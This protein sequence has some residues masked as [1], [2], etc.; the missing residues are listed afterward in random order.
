M[1]FKKIILTVLISSLC[2]QPAEGFALHPGVAKA[3]GWGLGIGGFVGFGKLLQKIEG[4]N[5][6]EKAHNAFRITSIIASKLASHI[7][8]PLGP[9]QFNW[10]KSVASSLWSEAKSKP[11][12][13]VAGITLAAYPFMNMIIH[14]TV[15][16]KEFAQYI[17]RTTGQVINDKVKGEAARFM[18]TWGLLV[19]GGLSALAMYG[20][21][22][23]NHFNGETPNNVAE[24]ES[25][26]D[27]KLTCDDAPPQLIKFIDDANANRKKIEKN[28]TPDDDCD[29]ALLLSGP[30]GTGK[31][32]LSK[33]I[34]QQITNNNKNITFIEG[35]KLTSRYLNN[36]AVNVLE[37]YEQAKTLARNN[38]NNM[39]VIV[40]DDFH[41]LAQSRVGEG[42]GER[43]DAKT[44][45]S[46]RTSIDNLNDRLK[47]LVMIA[48]T[49]FPESIDQTILD[50]FKER[51]HVDLPN[52]AERY[53]IIKKYIE[54]DSNISAT[55]ET[56][57]HIA[58]YTKELNKRN[59]KDLCRKIRISL[60]KYIKEQYKVESG[61]IG[62]DYNI[63]RLEINEAISS[64][65][66][67]RTNFYAMAIEKAKKKRD[68]LEIQDCSNRAEIL[69]QSQKDLTTDTFEYAG[70]LNE[71]KI[72]DAYAKKAAV[73]TQ[74][75]DDSHNN[76]IKKLREM[77]GALL[78]ERIKQL[79]KSIEQEKL[80]EYKEKLG[81]K[82]I[83]SEEATKFIAEITD[84]FDVEKIDFKTSLDL[85]IED[86]SHI[87]EDLV[88]LQKTPKDSALLQQ[89]QG[90]LHQLKSI[91]TY[92]TKNN[93]DSPE[94]QQDSLVKQI[95][96][97]LKPATVGAITDDQMASATKNIAKLIEEKKQYNA[98][99][100]TKVLELRAIK[101]KTVALLVQQA[102]QIINDAALLNN[103]QKEK[104]L[105]AFVQKLKNPS[106]IKF[107]Q[108]DLANKI[109]TSSKVLS[110]ALANKKDIQDA[111]ALSIFL[112]KEAD[113]LD[114]TKD[115]K[116]KLKPTKKL[117]KQVERP[118]PEGWMGWLER[119]FGVLLEPKKQRNDWER[120]WTYLTF[121]L[122]DAE[123]RG[124]RANSDER[125][126]AYF[127]R[128][129]LKHNYEQQAKISLTDCLVV[130][131]A[132]PT[133][134]EKPTI[135][136]LQQ[137]TKLITYDD[138]GN[139]L[140]NQQQLNPQL[141][142]KRLQEMAMVFRSGRA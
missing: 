134:F 89:T 30:T 22:I 108:S 50:Q 15:N 142:Q 125:K 11:K 122:K 41:E 70:I 140:Y 86:L 85:Q 14:H 43:D 24:A 12:L 72:I 124:S 46:F 100:R 127:A 67:T 20:D 87:A 16:S 56:I 28:E 57:Q 106:E 63:M 32:Y 94:A 60:K 138:Q 119:T 10:A 1:K 5:F 13:G 27:E 102:T 25:L 95:E 69:Q 45:S 135:D 97:L 29:R 93:G 132:E 129:L 75:Q 47:N 113:Q 83:T 88:K 61:R 73:G 48:S 120:E 98:E 62:I 39:Y 109:S 81:K 105:N 19:V 107:E 64:S 79:P 18:G 116:E 37:A 17:L 123:L 74:A 91:L 80:I 33:Y 9:L 117:I 136:L 34:A 7:P 110:W 35:I 104:E 112:G 40:F 99:L 68:T 103:P 76:D 114:L 77:Y 66:K 26:P 36:G 54:E 49:N 38:P 55:P 53:T 4:N 96:D 111:Q 71:Q 6:G 130:A 58:H 118:R 44:A 92:N 84:K 121:A 23:W 3:L 131:H 31:S 21:K 137:K 42:N 139:V 90:A 65:L 78:Q 8:Q 141:N 59:L 128:Q 126:I 52:E 82:E 133:F 51:V 115:F 2:M 101:E